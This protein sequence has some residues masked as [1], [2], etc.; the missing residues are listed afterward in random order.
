MRYFRVDITFLLAMGVA[1]VSYREP[2][3]SILRHNN[4]ILA[5]TP[6]CMSSELYFAF[7]LSE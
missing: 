6:T 3:E 7:K 2:D 4:I 1:F 5:Y